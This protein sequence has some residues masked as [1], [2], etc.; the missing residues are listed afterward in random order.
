MALQ[1]CEMSSKCD[2]NCHFLTTEGPGN[3]DLPAPTKVMEH[4]FV[5]HKI[6]SNGSANVQ[7]IIQLW[8][9]L[10]FFAYEGL[11]GSDLSAP[12]REMKHE[13]VAHKILSNGSVTMQNIIQ[14]LLK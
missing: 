4:G 1:T 6:S 9:Q 8:L 7:N 11:V 10:R 14:I 13:V 12:T 5:T 3:P 2:Y